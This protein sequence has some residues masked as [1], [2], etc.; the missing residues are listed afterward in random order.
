MGIR[1]TYMTVM[2]LDLKNEMLI[3]FEQLARLMRD[4]IHYTCIRKITPTEV[5]FNPPTYTID[6]THFTDKMEEKRN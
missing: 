1:R 2:S 4:T 5:Y 6:G 3:H